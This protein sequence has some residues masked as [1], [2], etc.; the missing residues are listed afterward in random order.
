MLV[1]KSNKMLSKMRQTS[2]VLALVA[3]LVGKYICNLINFSC[4]EF[5]L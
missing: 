1:G 5:L 3:T 2:A 4:I